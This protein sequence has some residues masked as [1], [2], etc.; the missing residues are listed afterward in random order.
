M[1][2]TKLH[3]LVQAVKRAE[4]NKKQTI[5]KLVQGSKLNKDQTKNSRIAALQNVPMIKYI[6][7]SM[8][9]SLSF[10]EGFDYPLKAQK[11]KSPLP[12]RKCVQCGNP[13][14]Y[15]CSR[16]GASLCSFQCYKKN[17]NQVQITSAVS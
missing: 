11:A 14:K 2:L 10:P 9:T 6:S 12:V 5:E 8:S 1:F 16:T 17:L 7:S 3:F 4:E 15:D 13:R